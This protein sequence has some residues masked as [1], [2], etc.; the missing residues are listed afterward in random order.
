MTTLDAVKQL[1]KIFPNMFIRINE[2]ITITQ[3]GD[4][5]TEYAGMVV[6]F[7]QW[8]SEF[9]TL[10]DLVA[11]FSRGKILDRTFE[12]FTTNK[13]DSEFHDILNKTF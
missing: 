5:R 3:Y 1:Q 2:D 9:E 12:P 13:C 7:N 6:G 10:D 4:M 11:T 8:E